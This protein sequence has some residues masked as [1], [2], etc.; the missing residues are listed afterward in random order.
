M[1]DYV[2]GKEGENEGRH[3]RW[4]N[5][6]NFHSSTDFESHYNHMYN[7]IINVIEGLGQT[8]IQAQ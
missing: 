2:E 8:H 7:K 6:N 4:A 1:R 5:T 3:G